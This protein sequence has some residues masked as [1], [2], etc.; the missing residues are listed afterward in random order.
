[1][2]LGKKR[3][4]LRE[5][6]SPNLLWWRFDIIP[7][8]LGR[9]LLSGFMQASSRD[10]PRCPFNVIATGTNRRRHSCKRRVSYIRN[11]SSKTDRNVQRTIHIIRYI[12]IREYLPNIFN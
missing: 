8:A 7:V 4:E 9:M 12:F 3:R 2:T 5:L 10:S 1:M 11:T 6:E